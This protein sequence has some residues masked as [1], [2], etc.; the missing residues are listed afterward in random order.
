[1]LSRITPLLSAFVKAAL[2][3]FEKNDNKLL[4]KV[5]FLALRVT[6]PSVFLLALFVI[7]PVQA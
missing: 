6:T 1:M 4:F 3:H 5:R 7:N 2:R